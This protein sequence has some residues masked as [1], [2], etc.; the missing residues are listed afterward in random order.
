MTNADRQKI[1]LGRILLGVVAGAA[2]GAALYDHNTALAMDI[3]VG[4][5]CFLALLLL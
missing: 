2:F 4:V 5:A 3:G 1:R